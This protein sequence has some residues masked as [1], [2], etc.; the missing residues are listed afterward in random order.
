M[1]IVTFA[2][3]VLALAV[4]FH[5]TL[6]PTLAQCIS[7]NKHGRIESEHYVLG[8]QHLRTRM[9]LYS[10]FFNTVSW[11]LLVMLSN[12]RYSLATS[13]KNCDSHSTAEFKLKWT[14]DITR[15]E[16]GEPFAQINVKNSFKKK[17][18]E[19]VDPDFVLSIPHGN[20]ILQDNNNYCYEN[21]NSDFVHHIWSWLKQCKRAY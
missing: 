21:N 8:D 14:H 20:P 12:G 7:W 13:R 4:I 16:N 17:T 5:W 19:H 3:S 10:L 18:L 11:L 2:G 6:F 15:K 1:L 9:R